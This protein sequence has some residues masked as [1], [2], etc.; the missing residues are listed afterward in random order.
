MWHYKTKLGTFWILDRSS[1]DYLLGFEEEFLKSYQDPEL[2]M[3]D[4]ASQET[5]CIAWDM[6]NKV[7]LPKESRDWVQG[8][9]REWDEH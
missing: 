1:E 8:Q 9:P 2:A 4:V 5:G 3:R 6:T 7:K